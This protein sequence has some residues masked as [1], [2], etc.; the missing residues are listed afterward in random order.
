MTVSR[1]FETFKEDLVREL[2]KHTIGLDYKNHFL[3]ASS[4]RALVTYERLR[5]LLPSSD[6]YHILWLL[7]NASI[8]F[9][10]TL[11]SLNRYQEFVDALDCFAHHKFDDSYLPIPDLTAAQAD[12]L[13]KCG[14]AP[15]EGQPP[16]RGTRHGLGSTRDV[17]P[18]HHERT[19]K[20]FSP[21]YWGLLSKRQFFNE[22][23]SF[24]PQHFD[25]ATFEYNLESQRLLPFIVE[26]EDN[27]KAG[28]FG[29]VRH[30]RIPKEYFLECEG[31]NDSLKW[32]SD[33][34][35]HIQ[36]AIKTIRPRNE[37][38]YD[39]ESEWRREVHAHRTL[40]A[41]HHQN[42]VKGLGAFRQGEKYHLILEWATGGSLNEF[43][44]NHPEPQLTASKILEF[45]EQMRGLADALNYL[46][47]TGSVRT[48]IRKGLPS[49]RAA[50]LGDSN[51]PDFG[52]SHKFSAQLYLITALY[53]QYSALK[54]THYTDKS[55][56]ISGMEL[57]LTRSF[58]KRSGAGI[59]QQHQG[60]W[61]LWERAEGVESLVRVQF[62]DTITINRPP[63][64]SFMSYIGAIT[65]I[66]PPS[67]QIIWNDRIRLTLTGDPSTMWLYTKEKLELKS[68]ILTLTDHDVEKI[69]EVNKKSRSRVERAQ[70]EVYITFDDPN[71]ATEPI[72]TFILIGTLRLGGDLGARNYVLAVR[73]VSGSKLVYERVGAGWLPDWLLDAA[74]EP[75]PYFPII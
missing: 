6:E 44:A 55:T 8:T 53:E 33:Q 45:L 57:R 20:V 51:F 25:T 29:D 47:N 73:P 50:F 38:Y 24:I 7:E 1:F 11:L 66:I 10:I 49:N 54:F 74:W 15:E 2:N 75:F 21:V 67:S 65:Y 34:D 52:M 59:F 62:P 19:R 58:G 35:R 30:V 12:E 23:W 40:N 28:G 63:S 42:I 3:P 32:Q 4:L 71:T 60:R 46:H 39:I 22:Q 56:A 14:G 64:W 9:S 37:T 13:C 48:R 41:I 72:K 5:L 16:D 26:P 61:L 68:R 43:W 18:C 27:R 31:I 70:N 69:A 17:L 36:V